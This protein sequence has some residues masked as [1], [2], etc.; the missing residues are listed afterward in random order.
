MKVIRLRSIRWYS[1]RCK[2]DFK[3]HFYFA[4][5]D[6]TISSISERFQQLQQHNEELS[7]VLTQHQRSK[8]WENEDLLKHWKYLHIKLTDGTNLND[9]DIDGIVLNEE[10]KTIQ[11]VIKSDLSLHEVLNY[12][13]K[14]ALN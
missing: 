13:Y 6:T 7:W 9:E 8:K 12:I 2:H 14:N 3:I 5:L 11:F 10:L 4:I 1:E